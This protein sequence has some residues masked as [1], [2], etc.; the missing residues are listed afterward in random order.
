M[1]TGNV[2]ALTGLEDAWPI[3]TEPFTQWV[4]EDHFPGGRPPFETVGAQLVADVEPF[5][6]MKLRML[7]G[8]HST[9]A[10]LGYLAG[11]EYVSD[12]I[13]DPAFPRSFMA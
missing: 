3:M 7:N 5:E 13:A 12:A 8:A 2:T 1:P 10:Y 6:R 9:I 4:I 11:Y